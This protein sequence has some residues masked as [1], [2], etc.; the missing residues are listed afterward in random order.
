MD[1]RQSAARFAQPRPSR[2]FA[3]VSVLIAIWPLASPGQ[4][5]VPLSRPGA[6]GPNEVSVAIDPSDPRRIV[7]VSMQRFDRTTNVAYVSHDAGESFIEVRGP[8]TDSRT[9]G[10]DAIRFDAGG[11]AFWSYISFQGLR[12]ERPPVASNG[13]FVNRSADGGL[14][15]ERTTVV[16]HINTVIPFEDK[17]FLSVD[18]EPSSPH[19]GNL[20]IAWTRFSRYGSTD[21]RETSDIYLSTSTDGGTSFSMPQRVSDRP[22]DAVDS[23]GTL[24]GAVPAIGTRGEVYLVWAGPEGLVFDKSEDGGL[25]FGED[26]RI[27]ETPG[28][29]DIDIPG[30]LRANGMPVTAVDHSSGTHRGRLY[31]NWVDERSGSLDVYVMASSDGGARWSEPVRVREDTQPSD[32]FLT[33]MAVDAVDGSVNVVFYDRD[34]TGGSLTGVSLARSVDGGRSFV[35]HPISPGLLGPF[36]TREDV[37]FGDYLGV[38]ALGGRVVA[39]FAHFNGERTLA[40]SAAIFDFVPGSQSLK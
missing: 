13:I 20:Y 30:I 5:L 10:D 38:D 25:S 26:R 11:R 12:V 22:G 33:W 23:D 9:Q 16:D 34:A 40:L 8:N 36:A 2:W 6:T 18:I 3:A 17:P 24:E 29:W 39:A 32:Q 27:V 15:W 37:F 28:G 19:R 4:R 7:A 21:P 31:V 1:S 35:T 14:S